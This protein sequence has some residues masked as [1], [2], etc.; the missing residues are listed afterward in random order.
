MK[1]LERDL[2]DM[3]Q[4]TADGVHHVPRPDRGL[5]R[6]ARLR[7]AR[8]AVATGAAVA[9][10]V[11]GGLA[12]ARSLTRDD[13]APLPPADEKQQEE[14]LPDGRIVTSVDS[15]QEW[16]AFDQD[17]GSFFFYSYV[18]DRAAVVRR[19]GPVAKF[20]CPPSSDCEFA[21]TFGPGPDELTVPSGETG[22]EQSLLVIAFDGTVRDT[23]DISSAVTR[24]Q[25]ITDLAWSPDGNR[26]AISTEP[27]GDSCGDPCQGKVWIVE[28][29]GGEPRL[30]FSESPPDEVNVEWGPPIFTLGE[31]AWSPDGHNLTLVVAS[32]FP[33]GYASNGVW[34]RLVVLRLQPDQTMRAETLHVYD[35]VGT[36][37]WRITGDWR[38][39]FA[40]AWS[41]DGTRI[42]VASKSGIAEISSDDGH[43]VAQNRVNPSPTP[44][45][46]S[47]G[48]EGGYGLLAWLREQ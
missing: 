6:R 10:L 17:T 22:E 16:Q 18:R 33:D 4:R 26:L 3:M 2:R 1:D 30:V 38:F 32:F 44:G 23:L 39:Y 37:D 29:G 31:L 41:P 34:P 36:P 46:A 40:S 47:P 48:T 12:G 8:T 5:V 7:R 9:V 28:P 11:V 45:A 15:R 25:R 43:V 13:A 14:A 24:E 27:D 35:D 20:K 21:P 19:S 42:A